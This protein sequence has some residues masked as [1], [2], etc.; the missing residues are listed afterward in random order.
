MKNGIKFFII[1]PKLARGSD[2]TLHQGTHTLG[3]LLDY[4]MPAMIS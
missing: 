3:T 1:R 4:A 2:G